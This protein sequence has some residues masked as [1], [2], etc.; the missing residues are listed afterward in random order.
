MAIVRLNLPVSMTTQPT[1]V[2]GLAILENVRYR[3]TLRWSPRDDRNGMWR[4]DIADAT[5]TLRVAGVPLIQSNDVLAPFHYKGRRIM[6][7]RLRVTCDP[8]PATP[9][10]R[11]DPG[12]YDFGQRARIEYVEST[13]P[14]F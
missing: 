3:L 8:D 14:S 13:D 6:P 5:G 1:V 2:T 12:L 10:V 11:V 4:M 7:G 9:T